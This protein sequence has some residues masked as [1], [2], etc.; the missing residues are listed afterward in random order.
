MFRCQTK[1]SSLSPEL[2][3]IALIIYNEKMRDPSHSYTS[4]IKQ[5]PEF[6][7]STRQRASQLYRAYKNH[8][9]RT[10]YQK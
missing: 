8:L 6:P 4:I 7:F 5:H 3:K 2:K 10:K 9:I 1:Y